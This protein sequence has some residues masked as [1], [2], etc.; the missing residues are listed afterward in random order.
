MKVLFF[1][2]IYITT[3]V[4]SATLLIANEPSYQEQVKQTINTYVESIYKRD[5]NTL[6][7]ILDHE[8]KIIVISKVIDKVLVLNR[9]EYLNK[10]KQGAVGG[11][12]RTLEIVQVDGNDRIA[13]AKILLK[14][15]RIKQLEIITLISEEGNWK[16]VNSI[17]TIE[18]LD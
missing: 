17:S 18:V 10:L 12:L 9:D 4:S 7:K 14:D 16:I 2:F 15:K 11:W 13:Y 8:S 3:I 6:D 1:S 5:S